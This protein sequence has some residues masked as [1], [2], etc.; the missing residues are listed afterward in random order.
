MEGKFQDQGHIVQDLQ[1]WLSPRGIQPNAAYSLR[2]I[3]KRPYG[4]KMSDPVPEETISMKP[5]AVV[6]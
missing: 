1:E 5:M 4:E 2:R 3:K 6:K